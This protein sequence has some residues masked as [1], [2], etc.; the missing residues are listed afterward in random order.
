[1]TLTLPD[2]AGC[3]LTPESAALH[4]AIGIYVSKEA[5]LGQA[6]AVAGVTQGAFMRELAKR[7]IPLNYGPDDLE[8][9]LRAVEELSRR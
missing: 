5:T 4:L 9:D 8:T 2:G 6:A 3:K 7:R 1:M